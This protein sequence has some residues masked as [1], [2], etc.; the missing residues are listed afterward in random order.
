[1]TVFLTLFSFTYT[2]VN[3]CVII[4]DYSSRF[5]FRFEYPEWQL[6][7]TNCTCAIR[8]VCLPST[9]NGNSLCEVS[10]K[11]LQKDM[12]QTVTTTFYKKK[13][14]GNNNAQ[15]SSQQGFYHW[16][17]WYRKYLELTIR[18]TPNLL[19]NTIIRTTMEIRNSRAI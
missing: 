6:S 15:L 4:V 13:I 14:Y 16:L 7:V 1:M 2:K 12:N 10:N 19:T 18:L 9:V 17:F 11:S 5:Y 3:Q 8:L